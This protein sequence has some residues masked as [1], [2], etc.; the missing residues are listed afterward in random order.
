MFSDYGSSV[1][2]SLPRH[3]NAFDFTRRQIDVQQRALR[4]TF[5]QNFSHGNDC[6]GGLPT[7]RSDGVREGGGARC[8]DGT[9]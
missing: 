2:D 3:L 5:I 9:A 8:L 4:Q 7:E 6:E 1:L